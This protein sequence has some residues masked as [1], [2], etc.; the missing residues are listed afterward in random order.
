M[1]LGGRE[2]S[3][4]CNKRERGEEMRTRMSRRTMKTDAGYVEMSHYDEERFSFFFF[5]FV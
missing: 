4:L 3:Q 5:V 2:R 1:C